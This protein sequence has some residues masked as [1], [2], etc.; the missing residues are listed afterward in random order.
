[1]HT[2][3]VTGGRV[4]PFPRAEAL[5][6][7]VPPIH[8]AVLVSK[9][10]GEVPR[11]G[12]SQDALPLGLDFHPLPQ[13]VATVP[14]HTHLAVCIK[15]DVIAGSKRSDLGL[16]PPGPRLLN[17]LLGSV[18]LTRHAVCAGRRADCSLRLCCLIAW[19]RR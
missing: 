17:W 19:L 7:T 13:Q 8:A 11:D 16:S 4:A 6:Q 2:C 5:P 15:S 12:M 18:D 14:V 3:G 10:L 1:M 9:D